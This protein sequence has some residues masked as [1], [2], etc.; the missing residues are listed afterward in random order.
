MGG[1]PQ[2]KPDRTFLPES[3]C[4]RVRI[5]EQSYYSGKQESP[6]RYGYLGVR[7]DPAAPAFTT[8]LYLTG[9][10]AGAPFEAFDGPTTYP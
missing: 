4:G 6:E 5:T 2:H 7:V 10:Q 1:S 3:T 9:R 8:T